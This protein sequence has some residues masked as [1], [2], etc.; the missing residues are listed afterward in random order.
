MIPDHINPMAWHQALGIARQSCARVF[1]DGGAPRDALQAFGIRRRD[2]EVKDISWDKVVELVAE[3]LCM[4]PQ[5]R[6]A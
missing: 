5:R 3:V 1:R 4:K 2:A 6:A